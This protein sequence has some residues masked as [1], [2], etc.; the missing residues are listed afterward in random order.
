MLDVRLHD[1]PERCLMRG[2]KP[3]PLFITPSDDRILRG[4]ARS[5]ASPWYQVRRARIVLAIAAGDRRQSVAERMQCDEATV[6]RASVLPKR[7]S[8]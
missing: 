2:R 6:W 7:D 5:D 1:Q 4:I 3:N 8:L